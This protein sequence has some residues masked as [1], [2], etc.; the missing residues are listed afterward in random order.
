MRR[1]PHFN[2]LDLSLTRISRSPD[3]SIV[4]IPEIVLGRPTNYIFSESASF[5]GDLSVSDSQEVA[6]DRQDQV[7]F[8]KHRFENSWLVGP[9]HGTFVIYY[10]Y[11]FICKTIFY[12]MACWINSGTIV[13]SDPSIE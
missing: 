4:N 8:G 9:D 2:D 13:W 1:R 6:T 7:I 3:A 10:C 5:V 11:L 12:Y